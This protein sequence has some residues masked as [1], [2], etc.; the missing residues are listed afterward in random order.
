MSTF[1]PLSDDDLTGLAS[2]WMSVVQ[3]VRE[4][5]DE[6][7]DLQIR[8]LIL[9]QRV[10]D[11]ELLEP[12]NTYGLQCLGVALGRIFAENIKELDWW[13]V[14]DEY[15]RDPCLRYLESSLQV[16]PVTMISKRVERGERV[17]VQEL[18]EQ[19][20]ESVARISTECE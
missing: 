10:L 18:F 6:E 16:N 8:S 17:Q 5:Y 4:E 13:I 9:L 20:L 19:T 7:F 15:G 2:Q 11:D 1:T 3:L 14:D 12:T